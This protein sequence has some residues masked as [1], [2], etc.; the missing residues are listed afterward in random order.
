[1][2]W[3]NKLIDV[4]NGFEIANLQEKIYVKE[5]AGFIIKGKENYVYRLCTSLLG[6]RQSSR[7]WN[8]LMYIFF[9]EVRCTQCAAD[10][11]F[12]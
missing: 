1:M 12:N 4:K 3:R 8:Q 6:L 11:T 5:P 2:N 9:I 10:P 7:K